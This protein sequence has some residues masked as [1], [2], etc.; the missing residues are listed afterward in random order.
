VFALQDLQTL[1]LAAQRLDG[2][3]DQRFNLFRSHSNRPIKSPINK[4]PLKRGFFTKTLWYQ[5]RVRTP[6]NW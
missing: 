6:E 2:G 5:H 4:K 1:Q 3:A